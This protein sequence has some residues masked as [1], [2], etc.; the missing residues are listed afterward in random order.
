MTL[1]VR[2]FRCF[3]SGS[4]KMWWALPAHGTHHRR[5]S[6]LFVTAKKLIALTSRIVPYLF[7]ALKVS[8]AVKLFRSLDAK[9]AALA[10]SGVSV[11]MM[12]GGRWW[13][14]GGLKEPVISFLWG[15]NLVRLL[16]V[17]NA[18]VMRV[19]GQISRTSAAEAACRGCVGDDNAE[20][21][22]IM[23]AEVWWHLERKHCQGNSFKS[24][25]SESNPFSTVFS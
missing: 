25:L 14:A 23:R 6:L 18:D 13:E 12:C 5:L 22:M 17:W 21:I 8:T 3:H 1:D 7:P 15:R 19:N 20:R 24:Q 11:V 10:I 2:L 4:L 16:T 9:F